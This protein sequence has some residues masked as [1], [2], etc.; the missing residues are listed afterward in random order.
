MRYGLPPEL[1]PGLLV[2][3]IPG[4]LKAGAHESDRKFK[5]A[6]TS[7]VAVLETS[8]SRSEK[9]LRALVTKPTY[10]V[11]YSAAVLVWKGAVATATLTF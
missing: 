10:T 5:R 2:S 8:Y 7:L 4:D 3:S 6:L 11:E 1:E 9:N